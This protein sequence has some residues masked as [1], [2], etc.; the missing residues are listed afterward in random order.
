MKRI[1]ILTAGGDTPALNATIHGAVQRANQLRIEMIGII[2]GYGGLLNP[3]APHV[4]LNPLLQSIPELDP[5]RGGTILGASRDYVDGRDVAAIRGVAERLKTLKIDGLICIGGDGT[6][7]G[8]QPLSEYL[9]TVLAPKTIDNDLGLNYLDEANEYERVPDENAPRG[10]RYRK[11]EGR[12]FELEEMINFATPGYATAVFVTS[13]HVQRIRTTAESHR[14][15]AI[16]EVM[17]RDCGMIALG[18]AYGQPDLILVPEIPIDPDAIVPRVVEIL[19]RQKHAVL[20]ISEGIKNSDGQI[21]GDIRASKDPAGNVQYSGA[22]ETLKRILVERLGDDF[23][24]RKRRNESADAAIF[25]RKIGH[26]Q[27]GGRPITFDRF[28]ASQL[29]GEA[30]DLLA[31]GTNNS[32]ATIQYRNGG[33]V[34]VGVDANR[35]RDP[36]GTIHARPLA[37]SFYDQRRFG[38]SAK[39]VEYLRA[40]F[41]NALGTED[42]EGQRPLFDTGNLVHPYDSVNTHV[43]KRIRRLRPE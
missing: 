33:F 8:M 10:Y 2:K 18:T 26:T 13:Q 4:L 27:R 21:L 24:T 7:N 22:A 28:Q 37:K 14:R 16:V 5:A 43:N 36:W 40:I 34:H 38:P 20:V 39:G 41:A 31:Q 19:D 42:L 11:R 29:G 3:E 25:C 12:D 23:F 17:G 1:G 9:P 30:V 6:L 35:L 32:L 15:V